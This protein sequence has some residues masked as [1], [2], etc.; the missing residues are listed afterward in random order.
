M[1]MIFFASFFLAAAV[2]AFSNCGAP[3]LSW[4]AEMYLKSAAS[5]W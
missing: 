4:V 2:S 1:V 3:I 5:A